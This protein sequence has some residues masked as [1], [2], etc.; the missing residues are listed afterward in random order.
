LIA[1]D[2]RAQRQWGIGNRSAA[3]ARAALGFVRSQR[4]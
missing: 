3:E 4:Q 2:E 1:V